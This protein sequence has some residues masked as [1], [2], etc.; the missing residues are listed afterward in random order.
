MEDSRNGER[1]IFHV[2]DECVTTS[3]FHDSADG[4]AYCVLC[5]ASVFSMMT[6]IPTSPTI[7]GNR[8]WARL[9]RSVEILLEMYVYLA[10]FVGARAH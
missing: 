3:S 6:G 9:G 2:G 5:L 1:L 7:C 10:P 8:G 4:V